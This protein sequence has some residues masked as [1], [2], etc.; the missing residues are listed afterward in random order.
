MWKWSKHKNVKT[1]K[2][3]KCENSQNAN[4]WKQSKYKNVETVKT[5][6][7]KQSKRK[8]VKTVKTQQCENGQNAKMWKQCYQLSRPVIKFV[9]VVFS[10]PTICTVILCAALHNL[11]ALHCTLARASA[12]V[13]QQRSSPGN[14]VTR[15]Y[16]MFRHAG[17]QPLPDVHISVRQLL[18]S[19]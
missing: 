7:W 6:M 16:K 10:E 9:L 3:K 19:L 8:N 15:C 11:S 14:A 17:K 5:K 2:M 18:F 13:G 4:M 1:V 12:W